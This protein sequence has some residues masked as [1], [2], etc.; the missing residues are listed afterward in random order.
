MTLCR[1]QSKLDALANIPFLDERPK[2][3]FCSKPFCRI[4]HDSLCK[5]LCAIISGSLRFPS[6]AMAWRRCALMTQ[7]RLF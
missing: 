7:E 5:W 2:V 4:A 6:V 3:I 1:M